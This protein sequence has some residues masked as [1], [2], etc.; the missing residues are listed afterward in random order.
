MLYLVNA[1]EE[2]SAAGYVATEMDLL[3]WVGK[4]V[5]VLLN[6]LGAPREAAVEAAEIARWKSHWRRVRTCAWS[7]RSMR[8]RAPGSRS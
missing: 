2:P 4:P 7:C 3:A 8:S 5:I 6:Q 1:S